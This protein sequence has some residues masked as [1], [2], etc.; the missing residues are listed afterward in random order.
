[1]PPARALL[2][3]LLACTAAAGARGADAPAPQVG[4]LVCPWTPAK[5][6]AFYANDDELANTKSLCG[7]TTA[8]HVV[9]SVVCDAGEAGAVAS[10]RAGANGVC[11]PEC[12]KYR[13]L[14]GDACFDAHTAAL[15]KVYSLINATAHARR[16]LPPSERAFWAAQLAITAEDCPVN[17]NVDPDNVD[18]SV[19]RRAGNVAAAKRHK[20]AACVA[21]PK[22]SVAEVE[23]A[24]AAA[25]AK[26]PALVAAVV[27]A[28]EA[29]RCARE[30]FPNLTIPSRYNL[31]AP[32]P[33]ASTKACCERCAAV[34]GCKAWTLNPKGA[35]QLKSK[36]D[37]QYKALYYSGA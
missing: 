21:G 20:Y 35:C 22:Q 12:V 23:A 34:A 3:L 19:L 33:A 10:D 15:F 37:Y 6:R 11:A 8:E 17:A 24:V 27:P 5:A 28:P 2:G 9:A 13:D 4:G 26:L 18:E 1:M 32:A 29:P 30:P 16:Q 14:I 36:N 25:V 7:P 31:G